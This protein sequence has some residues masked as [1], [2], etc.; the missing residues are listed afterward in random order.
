MIKRFRA[1]WSVGA[2]VSALFVLTQVAGAQTGA[3]KLCLWGPDNIAFDSSGHAYIGDSDGHGRA[4]VLKVSPAGTVLG[5]FRV[6]APGDGADGL[7]FTPKGELLVTDRGAKSIW[8]LNQDGQKLGEFGP[9]GGFPAL[10][11]LAIEPN[12]TVFVAQAGLNRIARYS[13][14]GKLEGEWSEPGDPQCM[15]Y[16]GGGLA[17]DTWKLTHITLRTGSGE[18]RGTIKEDH[19]RSTAGLASDASGH[20]YQADWKGHAVAVYEDGVYQRS[21]VNTPDN[22]LFD[23]GPYSL[24]LDPKG[25]LWAADGKS[26][27]KFTPQ[28]KLLAHMR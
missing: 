18:P 23:Q 20:L 7:E 13:P 2:L 11:H 9:V 14:D 24:A 27:V 12:G 19:I 4:R 16:L 25:N 1:V 5:D 3:C 28:G 26:V 15:V 6:F 8:R 17:V 10:G 22:H 21:I